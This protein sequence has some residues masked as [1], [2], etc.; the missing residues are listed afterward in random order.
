MNRVF[1]RFDRMPRKSK[2][3]IVTAV[4]LT[5]AFL[6]TIPSYAWFYTQKKAAEMFKVKYPNSLYINA[7]HR[8]DRKFFELDEIDVEEEV[9]GE[10]VLKKRYAFSVSGE[11]TENYTLQIAHTNNNKFVYNVYKATELDS[12]NEADAEHEMHG[13]AVDED[14]VGDDE[15]KPE[16]KLVFGDEVTSG[17]KYYKING[18]KIAGRYLNGSATSAKMDG[19]NVDTDD[20]YYKKTYG[21]NTNVEKDSVPVYWQTEATTTIDPNTKQ[22]CDYYI[23]EVEWTT[24]HVNNKE[25]DMVYLA[26]K[27]KK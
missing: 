26:V 19:E 8:E 11:G 18:Q 16:N 7:A 21:T 6:V 13:V 20:T 2:L 17:N 10:R 22:F 25:T 1:E 5:F 9:N 27:T 23:L 15:N 3:M 12:S 4:T 24:S 14:N